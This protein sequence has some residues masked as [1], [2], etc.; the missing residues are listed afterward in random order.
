MILSRLVVYSEQHNK[1]KKEYKF[2]RLGL[3][4]ILGIKDANDDESNG[5]GKT[6]MVETIKYLLGAKLPNDFL[7]K[8]KLIE[9][10]LFFILEVIIDE[11][12]F[13]L[14]RSI[15]EPDKCYIQTEGELNFNLAEWPKPIKDKEYKE[16]IE[17]L[18]LG[19][20]D[21]E[22]HPSFASIREY[23]LRDEKTGFN[24]ILLPNRKAMMSYE[25]LNYL[26]D[27]EFK[28]E[29]DIS[30]LKKEQ[31]NLSKKLKALEIFIGGNIN[32]IKIEEKQLKEQLK[33]LIN[34]SENIDIKK[35]TQLSKER[36]K[37]IKKD[38][39][40][41]CSK[42]IK[43]E[44]MKEQYIENIENLKNNVI[45]IKKLDDVE[46]F[47]EQIIEYFPN[48]ITKNQQEILNY[49]N[50]MVNSRGKYFNEKIQEIDKLLDILEEKKELLN[51]NLDKQIHT[52]KSTTVIDDINSILDKVNE[53]NQELS[54]I[55]IKIN[56]YSQKD[57]LVDEINK[58]K[59]QIISETNIKNEIFKSY[60]NIIKESKFQ[61]NNIVKITYAEEGILEFEYNGNTNMKDTTGRIKISCSIM[62]ENSH[63]RMYMKIN[64]FDL[65]WLLQRIKHK[66][67]MN[68]LFHDG[69]Y[70][71]PDNKKAK[72]RLL[73]YIDNY[74]QKEGLGQY[75]LTLN[76]AELYKEDIEYFDK[77]KKIIAYLSKDEDENRFLGL[78]Y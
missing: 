57:K 77:G 5:V 47:Y 11:N 9:E 4:I 34:I 3:N 69:S 65:T 38:Y 28:G 39:N 75:F 14:S 31:K 49:Y 33:N 46:K 68:F 26:F 10:N 51:A 44:S 73:K 42:I 29:Y 40:K 56:Q 76:L 41:I 24:D 35:N 72:M 50:F 6:S 55:E 23:V 52:L 15:N 66:S 32:S 59:Q 17:Q 25:I 19:D 64:M 74:M 53:K 78:K 30:L 7:S 22:V 62:D 45:K 18:I 58:I 37:S 61:F 20:N 67:K 70:V 63:G 16:L 1:I 2:N 43:L 60:E 48:E 12:L 8:S 54:N 36:Y 21:K 71:K 13:Y 27:I